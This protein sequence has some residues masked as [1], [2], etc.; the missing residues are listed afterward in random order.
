MLQLNSLTLRRGNQVLL[1][2]VSLRL[3]VNAAHNQSYLKAGLIGKNGAGKTSLMKLIM[4]EIQEDSG[5][6]TLPAHWKIAHLSQELPETKD[7]AFAFVR[8]GDQDY[9]ALQQKI[10]TAEGEQLAQYLSDM[11]LIDGYRIDAR[12]AIILSGLGFSETEFERPV[13]SFSGGWQMRLL[14]AHILMSRADL[15]LLDE[16][17]NHLDFETIAWL[18]QWLKDY[19]GMCIVI[20]HDRYFLDEVTNHTIQIANKKLRLYSGNYSS[21]AKQFQESLLLQEKMNQKLLKKRAHMQKFV[22]RFR[23]KAT[24][25]KQAQ[26]RLKAMEKLQVTAEFQE[27]ENQ[28]HFDFFEPKPTSYP[29]MSIRANLGY[30]EKIILKDVSLSIGEGDRIGVIGVNGSGK[31]TLLKSIAKKLMPATGEITFHPKAL[32]GYFSQEQVDMLDLN[33]TPMEHFKRFFPTQSETQIRAFLGRFGFSHDRVFQKITFFSGGE[34]ARL[35]LSVLILQKPNLLLLDEPTNHLDMNIRESLILALEAFSGALILVS[36]DRYFMECCVD[37]LWLVNNGTVKSYEGSL[38]E[39]ELSQLTKQ[40]TKLSSR[41][42][43]PTHSAQPNENEK[44]I[45]AVEKEILALEKQLKKIET[46]L[47]DTTLYEPAQHE[48]LT[49]LTKEQHQLK[50]S[51]EKKEKE[52]EKLADLG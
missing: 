22:D 37:S 6:I 40:P 5:E 18:T 47:A 30:N 1:E 29:T 45:H 19:Q 39:Y 50:K 7:T 44:L 9:V 21:F 25:A 3:D 49:A 33:D 43:G 32:I 34:K 23:A 20:S 35:A 26:S 14:L 38:S 28:V 24:K 13:K 11:E 12:V 17:T 42:A 10:E 52:W 4:G 31:S 2:E 27:D 46:L 8:S 16:P 41:H 51:L 15:L 36:H 48:K